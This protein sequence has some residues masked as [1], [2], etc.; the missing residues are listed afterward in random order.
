MTSNKKNTDERKVSHDSDSLR[1][2]GSHNVAGWYYYEND[3]SLTNDLDIFI[4]MLQGISTRYSEK[5][6]PIAQFF[7]TFLRREK[8]LEKVSSVVELKDLIELLTDKVFY[9]TI[10]KEKQEKYVRILLEYLAHRLPE[11]YYFLLRN[12]HFKDLTAENSYQIDV[13]AKRIIQRLAGDSSTDAP[14]P[15]KK[16][17]GK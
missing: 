10:E 15:K 11:D 13:I 3:T 7:H 8:D 5:R 14:P 1:N 2:A 17:K 4:R 12:F 9:E 16:K 6:G